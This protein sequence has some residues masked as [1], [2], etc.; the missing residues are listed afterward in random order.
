[1][2]LKLLILA[3]S[4][5]AIAA[6]MPDV[7]ARVEA[8][9]AKAASRV[10]GAFHV[11]DAAFPVARCSSGQQAGFNGVD[12]LG[13]DGSKIRLVAE[14]DGTSTVI[15]FPPGAS[16]STTFKACSK[17]SVQPTGTSINGVSVMAGNAQLDC[18]NDTLHVDG[19]ASF[20]CGL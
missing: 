9:K 14:T 1:M 16:T 2:N 5:I 12:A 3:A 17:L 6:C 19:S 4:T 11:N 20:Q 7:N 13:S 18:K 8:A 10:D 15:Y